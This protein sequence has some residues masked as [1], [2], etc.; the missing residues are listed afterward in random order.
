MQL[1]NLATDTLQH[2]RQLGAEAGDV[3]IA[4]G[5]SF[6]ASVRLGK[7]EKIL[8]SREKRMGIRLFVDKSSA[9]TSTANFTRE[10]VYA[11]VEETIAL[12]KAT[13]ADEFSG[14]PDAEELERDF[15]DLDL[16]DTST[17]LSP[18]E[19]IARAR[20]A[21]AAALQLDPRITNS[22][23]ADFSNSS[24]EV[25]YANPLGFIG[26]YQTTSYSLSAVPVAS[27]NG[28]MQRDYWHSS[29]RKLHRLEAAAAIGKKA[30]ERTLRRLGARRVKTQE[31][32]V[33]FDPDV[34][35]SLLRHLAA[36]VS[37]SS[38]YR[39]TSFLLD[40][41]GEK[42]AATGV[43]IEDDARILAAL[44]SKPFDGEGLPTRRT[45]VVED[46]V[47]T[48]YLLDTYAARKLG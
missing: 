40:K 38:L 27:H 45:Q 21:E 23:G 44:G 15:P 13:V 32:P 8:N 26:Q 29:H 10:A 24:R 35:A 20:E 37:G 41:L 39:K 34:A 48:S 28:A 14:L 6:S 2:A 12:A 22:E 18:E 31:A 17:P 36:A 43:W 47:L 25:L 11:L 3:I 46:G 5:E 30:A 16:V 9:I 1:A 4:A 33:V 19:K 7:V 42:I